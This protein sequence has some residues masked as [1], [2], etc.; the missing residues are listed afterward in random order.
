MI[1]KILLLV[2]TGTGIAI[3]FW[4]GSIL[5]QCGAALNWPQTQG[6]IISSALT[7]NHLPKFIDSRADPARWY[8]T[9]LQYEYKVGDEPYVSD[10]LSFRQADSPNP[11]D[12]LKV[13][14]KYRHER[15]VTVF[16]NSKN[17]QEAV[18][19]PGYIGG[20]LYIILI[21]GGLLALGGIFIFYS[22]SL[23]FSHSE[24]GRYIQQ[25]D[26]YQNQGQLEEAL[27]AYNYAVRINPSAFVGYSR[28]GGLYLQR[29]SWDKAIADFNQ[30]IAMVP[31]NAL[32]YFSLG[33]AYLGKKEY[34]KAWDNMQKAMEQGFQVEPEILEVIKK[35]LG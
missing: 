9:H 8:G 17:P 35:N 19:Q 1:K 22:Q 28:R 14:N 7:I 13:M 3:L 30:V 21:I 4:G 11:Q 31:N 27:L 29:E 26:I 20:D 12:A 5:K 24:E 25:G 15:E 10:R 23:E 2:T 34:N 16:Y 33:K 6:H 32:A 18:L